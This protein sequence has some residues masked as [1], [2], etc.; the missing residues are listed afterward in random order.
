VRL[1]AGTTIAE[2]RVAMMRMLL[3]TALVH[4]LLTVACSGGP[5]APIVP[6]APVVD[7][8]WP[9][10]GV[11]DPGADPA[12]V[13]L[14]L[15][16][17][18]WCAG[19]L[20]ASD[21]V[22]TARSCVSVLAGSLECPASGPQIVDGVDLTNVHVYVGDD[23]ATAEERAQGRAVLV[24][25]GDVLCG[26]DIALLLLDATIDDVAPLVVQPTGAP[27]GAHVRSV[28]C[29]GGEKLVRDHVAVVATSSLELELA[30]APCDTAPGAPAIDETSGQVVGIVSRS[31]PS[32]GAADGYD[33]DTRIDAFMTLVEEAL[34]EGQASHATDQAKE[35]KGPVDMG[36]SC[37][38]GADCAA[39]V[40][41]TYANA[42]YCTRS[43]DPTDHCPTDYKCM[44]AQSGSTICVQE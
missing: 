13:M 4:V 17:N 7:R 2:G 18:G 33:V 28:G 26:A 35:K 16:G 21:V 8:A 30:E 36:A 1:G 6:G 41:V 3:T 9:L 11:P 15:A 19:A 40:C 5:T 23:I 24:P 25:D 27:V 38:R 10:R 43:C 44:G 29:E 20:L 39:G 14:D 34:A 32:C 31:G 42:E 12:V 22:L 37:T